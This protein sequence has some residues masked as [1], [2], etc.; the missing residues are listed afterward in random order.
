MTTK[1]DMNIAWAQG[2]AAPDIVPPDNTKL[3]LGWLGEDLP[4][5]NYFNFLQNRAD[6]YL[7]H[8]NENGIPDWDSLTAYSLAKGSVTKGSDGVTYRSKTEANVGNDPSGGGDTV[9]WEAWVPDAADTAETI[10][11]TEDEKYISPLTFGD[12]AATT[13]E[14]IT[15]TN[16]TQYVSPFTFEQGLVARD[17]PD[18]VRA[19]TNISP[20]DTATGISNPT[21]IG[22]EYAAIYSISQKSAQFQVATDA[23]MS[24]I[25]HDS[26]EIGAT[27]EYTVPGGILST[28]TVYYWWVRYRSNDDAWSGYSLVTSFTT[29]AVLTYIVQPTISFPTVGAIDITK[30]PTITASAFAVTGG[31]DTHDSSDWEIAS[32]SAFNNIIYSALGSSDLESHTIP[33]GVLNGLT[34]YFVRV[35]YNGSTLPPSARSP[36]IDFT[37]TALDTDWENYDGSGDSVRLTIGLAIAADTQVGL[38]ELAD[39]LVLATNLAGTNLQWV[40]FRKISGV[41]S[42]LLSEANGSSN[43]YGAFPVNNSFMANNTTLNVFDPGYLTFTP[44]TIAATDIVAIVAITDFATEGYIQLT[45]SAFYRAD[46]NEVVGFALNETED[47]V[48]SVVNTFTDP[49]NKIVINNSLSH[50]VGLD[51]AQT[52]RYGLCTAIAGGLVLPEFENFR[53]TITKIDNNASIAFFKDNYFGVFFLSAADD[54]TVD[55]YTL[56]TDGTL[57]QISVDNVIGDLTTTSLYAAQSIPLDLVLL[58]TSDGRHVVSYDI[59]LDIVA[60]EAEVTET[61][62]TTGIKESLGVLSDGSVLSTDR[63]TAT[64]GIQLLSAEV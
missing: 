32:D 31:A 39:D 62:A 45:D 38:Y 13:G 50:I 57:T 5:H 44:V 58:S 51:I 6:K 2:A 56:E 46:D 52:T 15:G 40:T 47:G 25:I 14:V 21:L 35:R 48:N 18:L 20:A 19:P 8:L 28:T 26:G 33:R 22:D 29:A 43:T 4:P 42:Y 3:D 64:D 54:I 27:E 53:R 11:G 61:P 7:K 16:P 59:A 1:P 10:A 34:E 30:F 37:T 24:S 41:L 60:I 55:I 36:F 23:L 17:L 63:S 12:R 49:M 9:N